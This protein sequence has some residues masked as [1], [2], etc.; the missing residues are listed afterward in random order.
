MAEVTIKFESDEMYYDANE[1][2]ARQFSA[3]INASMHQLET[4]FMEKGE[5][6]TRFLTGIRINLE[7]LENRQGTFL[8]NLEG[9]K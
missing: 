5:D 7:M 4:E 6:L 8:N 9:R 1:C 3:I 2:D